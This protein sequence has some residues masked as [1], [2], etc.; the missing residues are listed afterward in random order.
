MLGSLLFYVLTP[1]ELKRST[2]IIIAWN[3]GVTSFSILV[4]MMMKSA[5]LPKMRSQAQQVDESRWIILIVVMAA[6]CTSSLLA[7]VFMLNG[8]KNFYGKSH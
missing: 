2:R 7:I 1:D 8:S 5:T 4:G 6:A 3:A